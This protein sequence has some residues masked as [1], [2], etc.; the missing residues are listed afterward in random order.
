MTVVVLLA[1]SELPAISCRH[2]PATPWREGEAFLTTCRLAKGGSAQDEVS[3]LLGS[4]A[5]RHQRRAAAPGDVSCVCV[6]S[7][8]TA[9][10]AVAAFILAEYVVCPVLIA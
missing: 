9:R 6:V 1:T 7:R 3:F 4:I 8:H 10:S 5:P 2:L